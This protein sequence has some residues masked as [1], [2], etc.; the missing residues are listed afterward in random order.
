MV[1]WICVRALSMR[2]NVEL[3]VFVVWVANLTFNMYSSILCLRRSSCSRC[4]IL[5]LKWDISLLML[6][7]NSRPF[8]VSKY[9][10]CPYRM[11][12]QQQIINTPQFVVFLS[13]YEIWCAHAESSKTFSS[14]MWRLIDGFLC[15]LCLYT[16]IHGVTSH[17][18]IV[19]DSISFWNFPISFFQSSSIVRVPWK[20]SWTILYP[21]RRDGRTSFNHPNNVFCTNLC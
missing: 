21:A 16:K 7:C 3:W 17:K 15:T 8:C 5:L 11:L 14:V 4:L 1:M 13:K 12:F 10:L 2:N 20:M 19:P 6:L 18:A 9:E